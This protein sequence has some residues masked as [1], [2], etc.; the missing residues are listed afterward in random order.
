MNKLS[1]ILVPID[2]S[3][4]SRIILEQGA[5]MAAWD[6]ATLHVLH[7]IDRTSL[8]HFEATHGAQDSTRIEGQARR[9][10]TELLR[11]TELLGVPT[12]TSIVFGHPAECVLQRAREIDADLIVLSAHDTARKRLGRVA[13]EVVRH[14]SCKVLLTRDWH[15][16]KYRRI[17]T[18][19]DFSSLSSEAFQQAVHVARKD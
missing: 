19:I 4:T 1:H 6:N 15:S 8:K 5:R 7:A 12:D 18:C 3:N 10:M 11:Q 2:F 17:A 9:L 16:S 13:A 14:A